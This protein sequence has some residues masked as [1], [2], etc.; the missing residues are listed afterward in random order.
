MFP[1]QLFEALCNFLL[2]TVILIIRKIRGKDR[3]SL[4]IY[5]A[6]YAIFRFWIEFFRGERSKGFLP[7]GFTFSQDISLLILCFVAAE[8][9]IL[10]LLCPKRRENVSV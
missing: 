7:F 1:T 9:L 8:A 6:G 5:L 3:Y 10:A 2:F 4:E